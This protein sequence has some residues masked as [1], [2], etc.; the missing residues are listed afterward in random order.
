MQETVTRQGFLAVGGFPDHGD[1][2]LGTQDSSQSR[3][4]HGL[5]VDDEDADGHGNSGMVASTR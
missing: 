4:V 3:A 2:L 5:V 1:V